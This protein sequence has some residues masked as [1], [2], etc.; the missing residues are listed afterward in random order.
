MRIKA[1][2]KVNVSRWEVR[3]VVWKSAGGMKEWRDGRASGGGGGGI[4]LAN[5]REDTLHSPRHPLGLAGR[6]AQ[7]SSSVPTFFPPS[8]PSFLQRCC[9]EA[10]EM[11]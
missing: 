11:K 6:I 5:K 7:G 2:E 10:I 4:T 1:A 3:E 8:F 9:R